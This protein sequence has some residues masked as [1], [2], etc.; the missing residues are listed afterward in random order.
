MVDLWREFC[1][2]E[3]GST[4]GPTP[5]QIYD[6][7]DDDDDDTSL[8]THNLYRLSAWLN[9]RDISH[10]KQLSYR[11]A[12]TKYD[13]LAVLFYAAAEAVE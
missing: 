13:E 6:D 5:W 12:R 8:Q 7:D 10:Y 4:S 9:N 2:R 1:I 3:N 11:Y